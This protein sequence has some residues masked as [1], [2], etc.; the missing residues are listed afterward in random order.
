MYNYL[1]QIHTYV[2]QTINGE[3]KIH[4][5]MQLQIIWRDDLWNYKGLTFV[6]H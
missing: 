5:L 6:D 4:S 2:G 1:P 3:T